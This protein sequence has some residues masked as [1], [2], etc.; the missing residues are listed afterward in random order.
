ML[1][2]SSQKKRLKKLAVCAVADYYLEISDLLV[3]QY[4]G[5][6]FAITNKTIDDHLSNKAR[7]MIWCSDRVWRDEGDTILYLKNRS[8]NMFSGVDLK[9][10]M[11]IK[12]SSKVV[13]V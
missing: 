6:Y 10:F 12:L 1:C 3:E 2:L 13:N 8:L 9:E 11:W 7:E 4:G 5:K